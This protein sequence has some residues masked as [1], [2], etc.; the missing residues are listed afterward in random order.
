MYMDDFDAFKEQ[1]GLSESSTATEV[2]NATVLYVASKASSMNAAEILNTVMTEPDGLTKVMEKNGELPTAALMY[3]TLTGYANSQYASDAFKEAYAIPPRGLTD[4]T[5]L[6]NL[7]ISDA[8]FN[9]YSGSTTDGTLADMNGYL[10]AMQIVSNYE[11]SFDLTDENAFNNEDTLK[12]L[13]AILG[14]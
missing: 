14:K 1:Y 10:G 5:T 7:M 13:N 9:E 12:L 6:V 4:V 8:R 3:G 2:A 11:D